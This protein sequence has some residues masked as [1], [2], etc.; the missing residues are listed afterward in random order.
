MAVLP[1][2]GDHVYVYGVVPP[3]TIAVA[4]PV[5]FPKQFTFVLVIATLKEAVGCVIVTIVLV[6]QLLASVTL[7]V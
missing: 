5:L 4:L 3:L 2:V 6:V 1:P 7:I